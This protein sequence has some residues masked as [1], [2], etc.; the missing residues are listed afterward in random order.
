MRFVD[1]F[2]AALGA[3][4]FMAMLM[5]FLLRYF[6]RQEAPSVTANG[7][8]FQ[9]KPLQI[10][11]RGLPPARAGQPYEIAFAFRGGL[12]P[13]NWEIAAGQSDIPSG[14][15]FD[16]QEG[17]LTGTPLRSG[18]AR[19]VLRA[20]DQQGG[21]ESR[22]YELAVLEPLKGSTR[23]ERTLA[24]IMFGVAFIFW[25]MASVAPSMIRRRIRA[26]EEAHA[27]GRDA[28]R[29][30]TGE[31]KHE[32]IA[33]EGGLSTLHVELRAAKRIRTFFGVILIVLLVWLVWRLW[34]A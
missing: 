11:T 10:A 8:N 23:I 26:L 7:N 25:L 27:E 17:T 28:I 31:G 20:K 22:P 13:V 29:I 32:E 24:I 16:P 34:F 18:L 1:M 2:M 30:Q 3:L 9:L 33:Y 15:R 12:P 21:L 4:V 14:L 19:F 6:P 5:A